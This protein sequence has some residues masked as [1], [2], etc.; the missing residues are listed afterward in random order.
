MIYNL[1]I[2]VEKVTEK[3]MMLKMVIVIIVIR[4]VEKKTAVVQKQILVV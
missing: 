3:V 1:D 4:D 2:I